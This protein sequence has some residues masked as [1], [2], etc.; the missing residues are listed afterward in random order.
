MLLLKLVAHSAVLNLA[1]QKLCPTLRAHE[2]FITLVFIFAK[3][4]HVGFKH[5]FKSGNVTRA[6]LDKLK[7]EHP[8]LIRNRYRESIGIILVEPNLI[9]KI[10]QPF[11]VVLLVYRSNASVGGVYCNGKAIPI[12]CSNTESLVCILVAA[13][14]LN[15]E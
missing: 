13:E 5:I 11:G 8:K 6:V 9:I 4:I 2:R 15:F 7:P 10:G 14:G 3:H 1:R 12:G